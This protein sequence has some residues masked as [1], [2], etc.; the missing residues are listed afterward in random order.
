MNWKE[1][2]R[3]WL[4][5]GVTCLYC[6]LIGAGSF[7][8]S[9]ASADTKY[10][11]KE[12][13]TISRAHMSRARTLLVEALAE[14][15]EGRKYARPD[16]LLDSEDWRLRVVSL[17]EQLNRVIDPKPRVT[18]EGAV[19][20]TPPRFVKRERDHL[21]PV[22]NGAKSRSDYGEKQRLKERQ[23]ARAR[24]YEEKQQK[25]DSSKS[26]EVQR[27]IDSI[28][29]LLDDDLDLDE[30][31][32]AKNGALRASQK[33]PV[34]PNELMPEVSDEEFEEIEEKKRSSLGY[35]EELISPREEQGRDLYDDENEDYQDPAIGKGRPGYENDS[36]NTLPD[37]ISDQEVENVSPD[38]ADS[39]LIDDEELTRRLEQTLADR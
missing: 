7:I 31:S 35:D 13:S 22:A 18:R 6:F 29:E 26:D 34:F 25:N 17:T 33:G 2:A 37:V 4:L 1:I 36:F 39:R 15:E 30:K 11:S 28:D 21:P 23:E 19:F 14:F 38:V 5:Q 12:R 16:L 27:E 10:A 3:A 24:L 20:R 8:P 32:E 9:T